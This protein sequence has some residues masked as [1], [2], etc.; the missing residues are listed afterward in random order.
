M[1]PLAIAL[2][3]A[4]LALLRWAAKPISRNYAENDEATPRGGFTDGGIMSI[5]E[6]RLT[7]IQAR[8]E[9]CPDCDEPV[10]A[11]GVTLGDCPGGSGEK[12]SSCYACYCDRSC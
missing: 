10:D 7:E 5:T 12:C 11:D 4:V 6:K 3:V 1:T 2:A 9:T 8:I